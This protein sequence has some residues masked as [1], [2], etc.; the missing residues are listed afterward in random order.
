MRPIRI[1]MLLFA[2]MFLTFCFALLAQEAVKTSSIV[3]EVKDQSGAFVTNAH[4]QVV[5][6]PNNIGKNLTTDL[7]G[8]VSLDLSPGTSDLTDESSAFVTAAKLVEVIN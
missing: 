8:K 5:P 6:A 1:R 3:V 7:A 4:I 2:G